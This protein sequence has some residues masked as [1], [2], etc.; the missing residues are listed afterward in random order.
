MS[1][2]VDLSS[3]SRNLFHEVWVYRFA[4]W[5]L[6]LKDF[7]IRYRNMSLGVAWSVLN[8]LVMLGVLILVFSYIRLTSR[9][10]ENFAVFLLL[11]MIPLNFLSMTLPPATNCIIDNAALVKKVIFP[12]HILPI[13][14]VLAQIVHV[15][16]QVGILLIF[17]LFSRIAPTATW[18]WVPLIFLVELGVLIG[19]GMI[20]SAANVYYRDTLYVVQSGLTVLFWFTP[21]IYPLSIVK[22]SVEPWLFN[23][24]LLNPLAGIIDSLR[25]VILYDQPPEVLTLGLSTVVAVLLLGVGWLVFSK[26]EPYF[27]DKI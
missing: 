13:S 24:Y 6:V 4:L 22:L 2:R 16:I 5:N 8:P 17:L 11:G 7:K 18:I 19:C 3:R 20:L 23:V 27:A 10:H 15:L 25:R 12:R 14:V 26:K 21:V 1:F 9:P